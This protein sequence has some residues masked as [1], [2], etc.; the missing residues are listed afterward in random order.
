MKWL[1]EGPRGMVLNLS[2]CNHYLPSQEGK[3][4]TS[5]CFS[6]SCS[7]WNSLCEL[8]HLRLLQC[9]RQKSQVAVSPLFQVQPSRTSRPTSMLFPLCILSSF[10]SLIPVVFLSFF[11]PNE[12]TDWYTHSI[13]IFLVAKVCLML[14]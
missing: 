6:H 5:S 4:L 3:S 9:F 8:W 2:Q 14:D 1:E 12:N 10:L 11:Y 13:N 7:F